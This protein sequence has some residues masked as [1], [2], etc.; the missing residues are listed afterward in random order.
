MPRGGWRPHNLWARLNFT[1]LATGQNSCKLTKDWTSLPLGCGRKR[2]TLPRSTV[3]T[4]GIWKKGGFTNVVKNCYVLCRGSGVRNAACFSDGCAG[5]GTRLVAGAL[6]PP[7][8]FCGI[9]APLSPTEAPDTL[10]AWLRA[11]AYKGSTRALCIGEKR[12]QGPGASPSACS[13]LVP[14]PCLLATTVHFPPKNQLI[15]DL[16]RDELKRAASRSSPPWG[17]TACIK[18]LD[19][20]PLKSASPPYFAVIL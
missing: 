14:R 15:V 8:L 16:S 7:W 4:I 2:R 6:R 11:C 19:T 20:T 10:I 13:P 12:G 1:A 3:G 18:T 5:P 17:F 9:S